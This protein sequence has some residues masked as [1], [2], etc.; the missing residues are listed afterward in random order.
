MMVRSSNAVGISDKVVFMEIKGIK[1][2][3]EIYIVSTPFLGGGVTVKLTKK[4][5]CLEPY[6]FLVGLTKN[7]GPPDQ[8]PEKVGSAYKIFVS[9]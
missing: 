6:R 9:V 1:V 2:R 4:V 8:N 3:R 5:R 7:E